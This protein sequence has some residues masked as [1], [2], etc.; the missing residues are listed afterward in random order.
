MHR[1]PETA[2]LLTGPGFTP[3]LVERTREPLGTRFRQPVAQNENDGEA[4]DGLVRAG[5]LC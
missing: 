3:R 5:R 2:I 1:G 4:S